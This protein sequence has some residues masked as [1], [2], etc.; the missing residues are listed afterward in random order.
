MSAAVICILV[1]ILIVGELE[2]RCM[3]LSSIR[4]KGYIEAAT[5]QDSGLNIDA[6]VL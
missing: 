5:D 2:G 1:L 3:R 4:R 6:P